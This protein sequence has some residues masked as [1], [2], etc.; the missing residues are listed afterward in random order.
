MGSSIVLLTTVF[1]YVAGH[2]IWRDGFSLIGTVGIVLTLMPC[3]SIVG[4]DN[5]LGKNIFV[6]NS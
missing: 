2:L 4:F 1:A 5:L 6:S 3:I